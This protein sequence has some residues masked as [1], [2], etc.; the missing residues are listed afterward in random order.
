MKHVFVFDPKSFPNQQWKMENMLDHIGEYFRTQDKPDFSIQISRYRRDAIVQIQKEMETA[1]DGDTV[2]VYAIGGAEILYDCI[3]S[4]AELPNTEIAMVP[5]GEPSDFLYNFGEGKEALFG[6]ALSLVQ[7]GA[8]IPTDIFKWNVN[9]AL[10]SCHIGPNSASKGRLRKYNAAQN[11]SGFFLFS[12]FTSFLNNLLSVFDRQITA[13]HYKITIDDND[14]SGNYS[15]IHI[16][17]GPYFSGK[18]TGLTEAAPDDGLL[19]IA[20]I[21][22]AGPL[23]IKWSLSRF[24]HGK[25]PKNCITMQ[26]KKITVQSDKQMWIQVDNEYIL[27]TAVNIEVVPHAVQMV[28]MD[29]L[30]YQ[31]H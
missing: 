17:N 24:F 2:R 3:N 25:K 11:K 5:Y 14:F 16:A 31:K 28:T 8:A 4:V 23:T 13:R 15:L 22:S 26:A 27:D 19:D 18:M 1:K 21:K 30:S 6:N 20:M 12:I 29:N 7:K 10:N 9:Y